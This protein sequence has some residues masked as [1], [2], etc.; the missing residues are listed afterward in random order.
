MQRIINIT[1][2]R[3]GCKRIYE[4]F[5]YNKESD[6]TSLIRWRCRIRICKGIL[7]TD[8]K[9]IVLKTVEHTVHNTDNEEIN[10]YK[11]LKAIKENLNKQQESSLEV[12]TAITSK[13]DD[14]IIAILPIFNTMRDTATRNRNKIK[15]RSW[16]Q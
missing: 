16:V 12:V 14:K 1:S 5:I 2:K 10:K 6:S 8:K 9:G 3:G 11:A 4:D 7:H 13:L 15:E